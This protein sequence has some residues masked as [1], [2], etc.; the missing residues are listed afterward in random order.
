MFNKYKN[1]P[2]LDLN[3]LTYSVYPALTGRLV[4]NPTNGIITGFVGG[5]GINQTINHTITATNSAGS[6]SGVLRI[7]YS[8]TVDSTIAMT[9][10][11]QNQW[12]QGCGCGCGGGIGAGS[13]LFTYY[14]L[15]TTTQNT[16]ADISIRVWGVSSLVNTKRI[17]YST[18]GITYTNVTTSS[19]STTDLTYSYTV[20]YVD[21]NLY[22]K[23]EIYSLV[24]GAGG[25]NSA[26][27]VYRYNPVQ[28]TSNFT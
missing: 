15:S 3:A 17:S 22:I 5:I 1:P 12:L 2:N 26:T 21:Q 25:L 23:L 16:N 4:L 6:T 20:P 10:D 24:Y 18:D 11:Q 7:N 8:P 14:V 28:A 27:I 19:T 9:V 13:A